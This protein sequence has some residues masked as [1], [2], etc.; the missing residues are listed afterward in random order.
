MPLQI[1]GLGVCRMC[2]RVISRAADMIEPT[3]LWQVPLPEGGPL[4]TSASQ[5]LTHVGPEQSEESRE[6]AVYRNLGS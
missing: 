6:S 4:E 2:G 5:I 3:M 1:S